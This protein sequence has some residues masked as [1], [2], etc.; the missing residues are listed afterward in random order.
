MEP[1][2]LTFLIMFGGTYG[3]S[4]LYL[5]KDEQIHKITTVRRIID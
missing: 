4:S 2:I 5:K 3:V 1:A